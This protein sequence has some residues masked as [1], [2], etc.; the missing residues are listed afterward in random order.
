MRGAVRVISTQPTGAALFGPSGPYKR[1]QWCNGVEVSRPQEGG[2][3]LQGGQRL[4]CLG[5]GGPCWQVLPRVGV[6]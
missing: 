3:L 5:A 4:G 1:Q 2:R 6:I